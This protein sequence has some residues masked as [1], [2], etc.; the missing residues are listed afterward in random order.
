[1]LFI[2]VK[3]DM[4]SKHQGH[5]PDDHYSKATNET[6]NEGEAYCWMNCLPTKTCG[7]HQ[8]MTCFRFSFAVFEFRDLSHLTRDLS[9]AHSRKNRS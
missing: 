6:C 7:A 5:E 2:S 3:R 8:E 1:M 9:Q 4:S